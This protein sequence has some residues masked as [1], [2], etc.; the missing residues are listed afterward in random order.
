MYPYESRRIKDNGNGGHTTHNKY[1]EPFP[2]TRTNHNKDIGN[3]KDKRNK[4]TKWFG[5]ANGHEQLLQLVRRGSDAL[6]QAMDHL[7][8]PRT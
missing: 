4:K 6:K 5:N 2:T 3:G 7:Q 8:S 1:E